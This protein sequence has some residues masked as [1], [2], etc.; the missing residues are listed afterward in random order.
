MKKTLLPALLLAA[1]LC[2]GAMQAAA[3]ESTFDTSTEGWKIYQGTLPGTDPWY[4]DNQY[5]AY[6]A[7]GNW[8]F[9]K[10]GWNDWT[11]LYGGT[12]AFD[13]YVSGAGDFFGATRT[14]I[15]ELPGDVGTYA[16]ADLDVT[17]VKE[18]W[19]HFEVK[20]LDALFTVLP[21][22][23]PLSTRLADATGLLIRGDLLDGQEYT[24]IDNVSVTAVPLPASL[25][26]LVSGLMGA[27]ATFRRHLG[28]PPK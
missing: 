26:L 13:L 19:T 21:G 8:L 4:D 28:R 17:P 7:D 9:W 14:V 10:D 27:A 3:F 22:G 25:V 16:Y 1:V 24:A 6:M 23:E 11:S 5:L 18:Q 12:I 15:I 20:I 2:S